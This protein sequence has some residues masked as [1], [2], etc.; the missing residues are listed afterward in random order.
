MA[1][2]ELLGQTRLGLIEFPPEGLQ[3]ALA[4]NFPNISLIEKEMLVANIAEFAISVQARPGVQG[5]YRVD[6]AM[7]TYVSHKSNTLTYTCPS[8]P[9]SQTHPAHAEYAFLFV[10][11]C[12]KLREILDEEPLRLLAAAPTQVLQKIIQSGWRFL[13]EVSSAQAPAAETLFLWSAK[14]VLL[15]EPTDDRRLL[16]RLRGIAAVLGLTERTLSG[17]VEVSG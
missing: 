6:P 7:A 1:L 4:I 8:R 15:T 16:E 2:E 9:L 14:A 3:G 17:V 5:P 12:W 10:S 13:P 11:D